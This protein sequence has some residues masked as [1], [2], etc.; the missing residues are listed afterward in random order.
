MLETNKVYQRSSKTK[1]TKSTAHIKAAQGHTISNHSISHYIHIINKELH[2]IALKK[3]MTIAYTKSQRTDVEIHFSERSL[4]WPIRKLGATTR[5][6]KY[7][8]K[9]RLHNV[10]PYIHY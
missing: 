3:E 5:I 1:C 6:Q 7:L 9:H 4:S 2:Q 10:F 8:E